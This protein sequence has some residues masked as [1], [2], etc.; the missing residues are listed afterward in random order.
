MEQQDLVN[1]I[2]EAVAQANAGLI[3]QVNQL[4]QQVQQANAAVAAIAEGGVGGG[5]EQEQQPGGG[6]QE[7]ALGGGE[8]KAEEPAAISAHHFSLFLY[9]P[10]S[11]YPPMRTML[12]PFSLVRCP[13]FQQQPRERRREDTWEELVD[14]LLAVGVQVAGDFW[15]PGD[16]CSLVS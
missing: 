7:G 13:V 11:S 10:P 5:Q 2:A 16:V 9:S 3:E 12:G 1:L 4:Q 14:R 15:R 8:G 6:G